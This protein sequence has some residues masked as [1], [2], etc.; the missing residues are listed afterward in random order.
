MFRDGQQPQVHLR[1]LAQQ[2]MQQDI[3]GGG[4]IHTTPLTA[5][6]CLAH[7]L[8]HQAQQLNTPAM[9]ILHVD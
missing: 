6:A 4:P 9:P 5:G 2:R 3:M 8:L 7:Q 1:A